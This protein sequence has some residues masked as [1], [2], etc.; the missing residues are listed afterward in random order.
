MKMKL[1]FGVL[2]FSGLALKVNAQNTIPK[3]IQPLLQ[4]YTCTACHTV[5]K[6]LVGPS[7]RDIRK[8]NYKPEKIVDLIYAPQP[9]NW[10]GYPPMAPMKNVP[11]PEALKIARWITTL[12]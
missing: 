9:K 7:F 10:P 11:K 5:D 6:R 3:D 2:L 12:K 1:V 4:K 8:K